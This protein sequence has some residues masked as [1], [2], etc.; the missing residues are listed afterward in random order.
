M[1]VCASMPFYVLFPMPTCPSIF[2]PCSPKE[3]ILLQYSRNALQHI[4]D[5][6]I[7]G[8]LMK[9]ERGKPESC[10]Y[11]TA[12]SALVSLHKEVF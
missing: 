4:F 9:Y 5:E 7:S 8:K 12:S 3:D 1:C 6:Q 11:K 2:T 10:S